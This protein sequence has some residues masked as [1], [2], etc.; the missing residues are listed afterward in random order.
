VTC[1][2]SHSFHAAAEGSKRL[3]V[4]LQLSGAVDDVSKL[5]EAQPALLLQAA[6]EHDSEVSP[7]GAISVSGLNSACDASC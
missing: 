4:T 1:Q 3:G 5:V 7:A 6:V 2:C